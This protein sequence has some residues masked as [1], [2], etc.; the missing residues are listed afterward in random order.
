M[1]TCL[2]ASCR[3]HSTHSRFLNTTF[4]SSPPPYPQHLSQQL[5]TFQFTFAI[6]LSSFSCCLLPFP[7]HARGSHRKNDPNSTL[8]VYFISYLHHLGH[9]HFHYWH[10]LDFAQ[11]SHLAHHLRHH[12]KRHPSIHPLTS[13]LPFNTM[14]PLAS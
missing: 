3:Y 12:P 4:I 10:V 13:F 5:A 7:P 6:S 1:L 11:I 14:P 2:N 9:C 8:L